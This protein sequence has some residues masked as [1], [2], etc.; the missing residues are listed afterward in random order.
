MLLQ[1]VHLL[2]DSVH[3]L[4]SCLLLVLIGQAFWQREDFG[5]I[6]T[7]VLQGVLVQDVIKRLLLFLD[8]DG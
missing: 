4:I 3:E 8:L 5:L 6:A 1:L 2:E 7:K